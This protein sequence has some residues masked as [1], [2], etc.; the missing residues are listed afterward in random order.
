MQL[1]LAAVIMVAFSIAINIVIVPSA[2]QKTNMSSTQTK[3]V[4][5]TSSTVKTSHSSNQTAFMLL[6]LKHLTEARHAIQNSNYTGA[7]SLLSLAENQLSILKEKLFGDIKT[8]PLPRTCDSLNPPASCT[9][10]N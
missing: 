5:M 6:V 7:I 8:A 3:G 2:A 1:K 4:N 10:T 9:A